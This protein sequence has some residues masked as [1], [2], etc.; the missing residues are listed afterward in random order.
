MQLVIYFL[1]AREVHGH[2]CRLSF[3]RQKNKSKTKRRKMK[4]YH[5]ASTTAKVSVCKYNTH[6]EFRNRV[7]KYVFVSGHYTN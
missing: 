3:G 1:L 5:K 6:A 4:L 7:I 2:P